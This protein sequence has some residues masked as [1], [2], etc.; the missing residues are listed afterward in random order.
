M[1]PEALRQ[2]ER[3]RRMREERA[4]AELARR[5]VR[6]RRA[7][8]ELAEADRAVAEQ[9]ASAQAQEHAMLEELTG[10]PLSRGELF[11]V[12]GKLDGLEAEHARL[13]AIQGER[14]REAEARKTERAEARDAWLAKDRAVT[15]IEHLAKELGKRGARREL[16][17]GEAA[18][19][20]QPSSMAARQHAA[21][22]GSRAMGDRNGD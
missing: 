6:L 1:K 15:K 5:S 9:R 13:K 3:L 4:A 14:G 11:A 19:E 22:K 7:E 20:D 2:L 16:A 10:R 21:A 8:E 17:L 12:H 18:E